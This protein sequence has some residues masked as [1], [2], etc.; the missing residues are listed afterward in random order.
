MPDTEAAPALKEM[1][2]PALFR[3]MS[4]AVA[5]VHPAFD[6]KTFLRLSL[7]G[8]DSLNLLQRMRRMSESLHATLPSNYRKSVSILRRAAPHFPGGFVSLVFPDFISVYGLDDFDTSLDALKFFTPFGSSEFGIRPFLRKDITRTLQAMET[9]SRDA[10]EHVRRL[11]SEGCRPRLPWSFRLDAV[12]AAP[13]LTLPILENLRTDPSLYVRKS[14]ANHLND[15]TKDHPAW[16]MD[17]LDTWPGDNAHAAW[18]M[19]RALR[20]LIKKGDRRALSLI[21]AG[22]PARVRVGS[23]LVSPARIRLG[24][25]ITFGGEIH[26]LSKKP[27]RLVID[28]TIHYVKK[29]GS[30]SPK[31]FKLKEL[32]LAPGGTLALS[33]RQ[34]IR[35]FTTRKHHPGLHEI[36][37]LINGEVF[38]RG[39]FHLSPA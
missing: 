18:I 24:Q 36:D 17:R 8:L 37:L 35:D 4:R 1:F 11:S 9:W 38:A 5:S 28:Y 21:G 27:Q 33:R 10:D 15:L 12:I 6:T 23:F 3:S 22:E 39:S 13:S 7:D 31:V 34:M 29:S 19:K 20:T 25:A 30:A 14:V 26:S 16:V 32:T 2:N